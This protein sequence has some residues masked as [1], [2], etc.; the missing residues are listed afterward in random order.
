MSAAGKPDVLP[1]G[2]LRCGYRELFSGKLRDE[3]LNR[4]VFITLTEARILI[5]RWRK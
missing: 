1:S 2:A 3:L 4:E 5:K